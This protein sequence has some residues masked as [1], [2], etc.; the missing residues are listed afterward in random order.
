[1]GW[2]YRKRIQIRT[3]Q[4]KFVAQWYRHELGYTRIQDYP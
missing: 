1:M 4:D 2:S 3:I